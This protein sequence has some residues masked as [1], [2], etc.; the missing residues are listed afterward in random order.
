MNGILKAARKSQLLAEALP[1]GAVVGSAM[2]WVQEA[3]ADTTY[4][5]VFALERSEQQQQALPVGFAQIY[6]DAEDDVFM[7]PKTIVAVDAQHAAVIGFHLLAIHA[8]GMSG[9]R[10]GYAAI[11]R[12][13]N[14]S[15]GDYH[16]IVHGK[17]AASVKKVQRWSSAWNSSDVSSHKIHVGV[18]LSLHYGT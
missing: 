11:S 10:F 7:S 5:C 14:E 13:I 15:R 2:G 17:K 3:V 4:V 1:D 9:E 16:R 18:T 6:Y 8:L 12:R